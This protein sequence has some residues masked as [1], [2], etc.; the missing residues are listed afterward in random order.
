MA[1]HL[2]P[3]I[4]VASVITPK[5]AV[6]TESGELVGR[7]VGVPKH[8][9]GLQQVVSAVRVERRA[10]AGGADGLTL[11]I[12]AS[13]DYIRVGRGGRQF[14]KS[15]LPPDHRHK[16]VHRTSLLRLTRLRKSRHISL[17]V[18]QIGDAI[19]S[20]QFVRSEER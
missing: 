9:V 17:V 20:A 5:P 10:N 16:P 11:V 12:D 18:D 2:A 4:Q 15:T 13:G 7:A 1:D 19:R 6:T 8:S 3:V 14:L